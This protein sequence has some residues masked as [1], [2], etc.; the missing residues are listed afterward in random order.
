MNHLIMNPEP[1]RKAVIYC[2]VSDRKQDT[3]GNGLD[4]Q[5]Y[6]CR[7]Y[8][9]A[10][11][12]E[13]E[14]IFPDDITGKGDFI[15][16]PGMVAL[17]A[18]LDARPDE[19]F[20]VIFD[21][22]KRYA[23]DTEF[24]L[25]LRRIMYER[26]AVRECLNYNFEDSPEGLFF[27]TIAAAQG[28]LE[29]EQN[30][31]QVTQKM[32]V[33]VERGYYCF[34]TILGYRYAK[35][36]DGGKMLVPHEAIAPVMK[37]AL[38][39]FAAGRFQTTS[40]VARFIN[41][42]PETKRRG[43]YGLSRQMAKN[44]LLNPIYAGYMNVPKWGI[45]MHPGKHEPLISLK[46]WR[47]IQD[48]LAGNAH[49]PAR[50]DLNH[51][52]PLRGFIACACCGNNL[53]AAWSKGRNTH[54]PYYTCQNRHCEMKG[55]SVRR[56]KIEGEFETLLKSITPAPRVFAMVKSMFIQRWGQMTTLS[57]QT[58]DEARAEIPAIEAKTGKLVERIMEA[59][60]PA[61]I[62]AYEKQIAALDRRRL[63]LEDTAKNASPMQGKFDDLY[64]TACT[65]L[66]NPHKLWASGRYELQRI[67]LRMLFTE[68]I[69][70]CRN[71]GYRT[72]P[73]S[74]PLRLVASLRTSPEGV[75]GRIGLEPMT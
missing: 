50:Q 25:R 75:V 21:D 61:V 48:R 27:E 56:E 33:R 12:Y 52:F 64:R 39:G 36:K 24:H 14:A 58:A 72:A 2:R 22:L 63:F 32:R 38:E 49:A 8:A 55:K 10:K 5:E 28:Q 29:R 57:R 30:G 67:V 6:R 37:E 18:Y 31:R 9:E 7:Q 70:Y 69:A 15:N 47:K 13:V 4:S 26:G 19:R 44:A 71:E 41:G 60:N 54:Y 3:N 46:T 17:L 20:V 1:P 65:V 74:E 66:A 73:I 43:R 40:E 35:A 62:S 53:T 42:F 11:G 68:R 45:S 34:G 51:D 59:T 23:R 16:R